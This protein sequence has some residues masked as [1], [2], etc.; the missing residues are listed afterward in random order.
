MSYR[1]ARQAIQILQDY[2]DLKAYITNNRFERDGYNDVECDK[3][4]NELLDDGHHSGYSFKS[5][6]AI[7]IEYYTGVIDEAEIKREW[8]CYEGWFERINQVENNEG[9]DSNYELNG[10]TVLDTVSDTVSDNS[11]INN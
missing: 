1:E 10:G 6:I 9:V 5:L 8:S 2:P 11:A 7:L 4:I 3:L